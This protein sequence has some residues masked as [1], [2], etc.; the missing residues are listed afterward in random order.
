[1][2]VL[3]MSILK[4]NLTFVASIGLGFLLLPMMEKWTSK[5]QS[6]LYLSHSDTTVCSFDEIIRHPALL[7][8]GMSARLYIT[9]PVI[10]LIG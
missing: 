5:P 10:V 3:L 1:M 7:L 6:D 9:F 4:R 8:P 2:S